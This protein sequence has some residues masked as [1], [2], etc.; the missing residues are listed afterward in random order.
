V[1]ARPGAGGGGGAARCAPEEGFRAWPC[2]AGAGAGGAALLP[3]RTVPDPTF[4][5]RAAFSAPGDAYAGGLFAAACDAPPGLDSGAPTCTT[6]VARMGPPLR[7]E[8]GGLIW[9]DGASGR[10]DD[11]LSGAGWPSPCGAAA[12]PLAFASPAGFFARS[13]ARASPCAAPSWP[14]SLSPSSGPLK[15]REKML[16]SSP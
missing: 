13:P 12:R 1:L 4:F 5:G 10:I 14:G 6:G 11:L 9:N 8:S 2:D 3:S 16:I 15:R 7:S